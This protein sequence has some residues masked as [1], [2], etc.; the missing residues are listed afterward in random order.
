MKSAVRWVGLLS[1]VALV[2]TPAWAAE[3]RMTGYIDNVFPHF[4]SNVSQA[5]GDFTR[6]EDQTTMGRTRG[7][8]Y[9]NIIGSD[10][11]RGVAG[12][13]IDGVWGA[14]PEGVECF[15]RNTDQMN[16]K[17]KWLYA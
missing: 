15:D 7:R 6:N 17:T 9:F 16:I 12:F 5:D 8:L 3:L 11:L 14:C 4:R 2:I 1:V 10:N 13:E